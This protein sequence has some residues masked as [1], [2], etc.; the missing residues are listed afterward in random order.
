M[1]DE[2]TCEGYGVWRYASCKAAAAAHTR[3]D[4]TPPGADG[5]DERV[6]RARR[7]GFQLGARVANDAAVEAIAQAALAILGKDRADGA[8]DLGALGVWV[9][10]A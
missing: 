4:V 2:C 1:T 9:R 6:N 7:R 3:G 8:I 10:S 5:F